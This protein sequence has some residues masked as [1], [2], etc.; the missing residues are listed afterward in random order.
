[1]LSRGRHTERVALRVLP[2]EERAPI[3]REFPR[4]VP[5]GVQFFAHALHLPNDP[6]ALAAAAPQCP[7][8]CIDVIEPK[9]RSAA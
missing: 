9:Q 1:M 2:V 4:Q 5:H 7:V 8:V 6:D 3:L